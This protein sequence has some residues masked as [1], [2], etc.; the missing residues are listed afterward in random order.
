MN[1]LVCGDFNDVLHAS[2]RSSGRFS[3]ST[4][5]FRDF[6]LE[7]ELQDLPLHGRDY[8]WHNSQAFSRIDRVLASC[9]ILDHWPPMTIS[10]VDMTLSNHFPILYQSHTTSTSGPKP[11]RSL[12]FWWEHADFLPLARS[13]WV[14][15]CTDDGNKDINFKL[16]KLRM[17]IRSWHSSHFGKLEQKIKE[18]ESQILNLTSSSVARPIPLDLTSALT[19]ARSSLLQH[20]QELEILRHQQSRVSLGD[21]NTSFFHRTASANYRNNRISQLDINGNLMFHGPSITSAIR[22]FY[23]NL[24]AAP[25][26]VP[27]SLRRFHFN[28]VS[29]SQ[30][31][32]LIA[33]FSVEEVWA[34]ICAYGENKAPGPDGFNFFFFKRFWETMKDE[35]MSLFN[36]FHDTS[37]LSDSI[38]TSF[39]VLIPKVPGSSSLNNFQP[40]ALIHGIYK[41]IA[42]LLSTRLQ[43]VIPNLISGNQFAF[44]KGRSIHESSFLASEVINSIHSSRRSC[45]ILKPDFHKAFDS[46][47]WNYIDSVLRIM[48]FEMKWLSWLSNCRKNSSSSILINGSPSGPSRLLRGVK[49]GDPLSPFFICLGCRGV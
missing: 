33:P 16:K 6:V 30:N 3:N 29:N 39:T 37:L 2:D 18:L 40:N 24:F 28:T 35:V 1:V 14:Q 46:I 49:Q 13:S 41:I 5:T 42:K 15:I 27:F 38:K 44:V 34:S 23:D 17:A 20:S 26:S 8:T 45:L 12:N 47:S 32:N 25:P 21:G 36:H 7:S 9:D 43:S 48:S 19:L 11:F 4:G 10:T 31:L 22:S